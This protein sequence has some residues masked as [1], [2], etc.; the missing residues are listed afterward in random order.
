MTTTT[1]RR[2]FLTGAL[3]TS[4]ATA[5]PTPAKADTVESIDAAARALADAMARLHGG[6][7]RAHVDH[8][9]GFVLVQPI[10]GRDGG[11]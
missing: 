7:W 4:A 10:I 2:A 1:A 5:L 3:S 9:T 11:R 8:N 6:R